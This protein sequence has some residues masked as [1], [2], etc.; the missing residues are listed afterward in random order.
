[1][2]I[3]L[4]E[5]VENVG[6]ERARNSN[7]GI[8][9]FYMNVRIRSRQRN[10]HAAPVGCELDCVRN[11][12]PYDLL[13]PVGVAGYDCRPVRTVDLKFDFLGAGSRPTRFHRRVDYAC[14]I[15]RADIQSEFAGDDAR[16]VEKVV[17]YPSL[18]ACA[19][20]DSFQRTSRGAL[21]EI[22]IAQ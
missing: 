11:Q 9:Y 10:A 15:D 21:V 14:H 17:D 22:A 3:G 2:S 4:P 20:F 12:V 19:A 5:P 6:Q 18:S 1:G 8:A 16:H 13:N 7:P